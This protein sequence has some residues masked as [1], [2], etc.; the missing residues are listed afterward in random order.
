MP[1]QRRLNIKIQNLILL[2]FGNSKKRIV[3]AG[4]LRRDRI[5]V[6]LFFVSSLS[7][8]IVSPSALQKVSEPID[9]GM[10]RRGKS[11]HDYFLAVEIATL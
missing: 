1:L 2:K 6:C 8:G 7:R 10:D 9:I 5:T 3:R 11:L 4:I